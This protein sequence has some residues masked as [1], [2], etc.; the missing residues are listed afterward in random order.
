MM[1]RLIN[2]LPYMIYRKN[3]KPVHVR[4]ITIEHAEELDIRRKERNEA[5]R[6]DRE[7]ELAKIEAMSW[8]EKVAYTDQI[9]DQFEVY[10]D[11]AAEGIR[12]YA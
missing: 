9:M 7:A 6:I 12:G 2:G 3:G 1:T 8:D 10:M 11:Q 5:E 4:A